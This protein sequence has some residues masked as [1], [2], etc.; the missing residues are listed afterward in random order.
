MRNVG[1]ILQDPSHFDAPV[2]RQFAGFLFTDVFTLGPS[3]TLRHR[4]IPLDNTRLAHLCGPLDEHLR[5]IEAALGVTLARRGD[6][7]RID[8][9]KGRPEEALELLE[10]LYAKSARQI[11]RASCRE[12][13]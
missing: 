3:M 7:F 13:V 11:G 12:R 6:Q 2:K 9:A 10:T 4:F 1:P 5:T 8:G